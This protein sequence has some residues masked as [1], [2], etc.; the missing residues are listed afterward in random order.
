MLAGLRAHDAHVAG[1]ATVPVPAA[2]V[3]LFS[4][5]SQAALRPKSLYTAAITKWVIDERIAT[6]L[7]RTTGAR[8]E[9]VALVDPNRRA[10]VGATRIDV[11]VEACIRGRSAAPGGRA[12]SAPRTPIAVTAVT[13]PCTSRARSAPTA[14]RDDLHGAAAVEQRKNRAKKRDSP[15]SPAHEW[16]KDST[17]APT[18]SVS[19]SFSQA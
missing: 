19:V 15:G 4:A 16:E 8:R 7:R 1:G 10:N 12:A 9:G 17:E 18:A 3:A 5:A 2:F 13:A 14:T 6:E 11:G